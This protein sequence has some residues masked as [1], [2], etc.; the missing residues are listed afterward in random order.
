V[1]RRAAPQLQELNGLRAVAVLLVIAFHSWLFVKERLVDSALSPAF[2]ESLPWVLR[3]IRRGDVGVDVFFVL[4]GFL[5]AWQLFQE[6]TVKGRI[7][8]RAFYV[9]RLVRIYP[10]YLVALAISMAAE[11]PQW[12]Y[13]GN[14]LTYNIWT[15]PLSIHIPWSWSLSVELQFYLVVPLLIWAFRGPRSAWALALGF[16]ALAIGW[17]IR[18]LIVFPSVATDSLYVMW[19]T[20][21]HEAAM[22]W[23]RNLYAG[24]GVRMAQFVLGMAAAWMVVYRMVVVA[25]VGAVARRWLVGV[26]TL[27]AAVPFLVNPWAPVPE[28]WQPVYAFELISARVLFALAVALL[29]A[30]M[31]AGA[32]PQ[33]KR[34]LSAHWLGVIAKYSFSMYLFHPVFIA[35]GIALVLGTAPI[36]GAAT[37]Q[38]LVVFAVGV[39][40]STGF[41]WL[42]WRLIE[43]P[44][45]RRGRRFTGAAD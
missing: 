6:R 16:S 32:L 13:L 1:S 19:E 40:G 14:I 25:V 35:A 33:V 30:L 18:T 8:V 34:A 11:G 27:F 38:L 45:M 17:S 15:D 24:M 29:I 12:S 5:L 20:P 42:T 31:Y 44:A 3:F 37:W 10:L 9:K 36:E 7:D 28:W 22:A 39:A 2:S 4:S 41:G 21:G 26:I 43:A 23:A